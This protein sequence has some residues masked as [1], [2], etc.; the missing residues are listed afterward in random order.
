MVDF[1]DKK[2]T[3]DTLW[4][5]IILFGRN[6]ACYKFALA[7]SLLEMIDQEKTFIKLDDLAVPFAK[8]IT[9]H[10]EANDKQGTSPNSKFLSACRKFNRSEITEE[11]LVLITAKLG[12]INVIDAFHNVNNGEVPLRFFMDDRKTKKGITITDDLLKLK[13]NSQ[14]ENLPLE[15][16][17]R[18]RL[19]ETAWELNVSANLLQ[20]KH[21]EGHQLLFIAGEKLRRINI[22]SSR[23]ALNGYQKGKCF[24]CF[25]DI[26]INQENPEQSA[27]VDHFYPHVLL[28]TDPTLNLNGV[29]NLVLSCQSCN[30]GDS[31]KFAKIPLI[32]YLQRL[33]NRNEF[34]ISSH[35]P[36][37]E[38]LLLQCG[39]DSN[40]R[41]KFLQKM[42]RFA[43]NKL[44]HRWQPIIELPASF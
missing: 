11:E 5:A 7:K 1:I 10:L 41:T 27:D 9:R 43:I 17:S 29:W 31:G 34:L 35:H 32:K 19:V 33:H 38:T 28:E 37:R 16:E 22:T 4:R 42:D 30:R 12:F 26:N 18:W 44:V 13:E 6:V 20:V 8:H 3:T 36:L 40:T 2:P 15:L 24:Y 14:L 39:N 25:R 23:E 21:D